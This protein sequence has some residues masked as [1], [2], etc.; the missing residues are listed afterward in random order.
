MITRSRTM[1]HSFDARFQTVTVCDEVQVKLH[2]YHSILQLSGQAC[3]KR[4]K[5]TARSI[6]AIPHYN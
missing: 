1:L 6:R 3:A 4:E 2:S 5:L